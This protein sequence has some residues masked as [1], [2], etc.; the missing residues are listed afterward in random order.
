VT[1][2]DSSARPILKAVPLD[3]GGVLTDAASLD[4]PVLAS[5]EVEFAGGES[6]Q[7][8]DRP[9]LASLEQRR[10]AYDGELAQESG[11]CAFASL[12]SVPQALRRQGIATAVVTSSRH[13]THVLSAA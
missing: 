1:S 7:R 12:T 10:D 2:S 9:T 6:D 13:C 8:A 11:P 3:L 4:R 5:Q